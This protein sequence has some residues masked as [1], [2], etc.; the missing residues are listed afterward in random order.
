MKFIYIQYMDVGLY[1]YIYFYFYVYA[2]FSG[3]L[4]AIGPYFSIFRKF[5]VFK[6]QIE[7]YIKKTTLSSTKE[8]ELVQ[9]FRH[10]GR[11]TQKTIEKK[12][13]KIF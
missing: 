5:S 13:I 9:F 4:L 7:P 1:I 3:K 11:L 6:L 8:G 12:V 2:S 10:K